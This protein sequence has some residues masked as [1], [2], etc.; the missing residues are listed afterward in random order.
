MIAALTVRVVY[1]LVSFLTTTCVS[2]VFPAW[3]PWYKYYYECAMNGYRVALA[4]GALDRIRNKQPHL[5]C[6]T[7]KQKIYQLRAD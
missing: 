3:V 5:L 2:V 4:F 6:G 7:K 1:M